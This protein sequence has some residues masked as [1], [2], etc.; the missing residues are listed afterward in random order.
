MMRCSNCDVKAGNCAVPLRLNLYLGCVNLWLALIAS[1]LCS[2]SEEHQVELKLVPAYLFVARS[3]SLVA[4]KSF[5]MEHLNC[6]KIVSLHHCIFQGKC[7]FY[8]SPDTLH[9]SLDNP[10]DTD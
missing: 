8:H 2:G 1:V 4:A 6:K 7:K 3:M 9:N 10:L 5:D